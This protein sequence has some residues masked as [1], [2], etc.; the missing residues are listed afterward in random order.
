MKVKTKVQSAKSPKKTVK[1]DSKP[2]IK[3]PLDEKKA[4]K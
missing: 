2:E 3:K 1:S 4:K